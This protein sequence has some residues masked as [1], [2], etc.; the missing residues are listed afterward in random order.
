MEA[1]LSVIAGDARQEDVIEKAGIK[2]ARS[3]YTTMDDSSNVFV[4]LT[5]KLMNPE[6]SVVSKSDDISHNMEKLKRA[7]ADE[8]VACHDVGARVMVNKGLHEKNG[9]N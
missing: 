1:G 4:T 3:L 5:A 2:S 7:G 6:I 9:K 8:I